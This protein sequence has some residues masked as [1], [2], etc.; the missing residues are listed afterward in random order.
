[1]LTSAVPAP[2]KHQG[3]LQ[4]L[5]APAHPQ[6]LYPAPAKHQAIS[7]TLPASAHPH[8]RH[9][10]PQ[11]NQGTPPTQPLL[12]LKLQSVSSATPGPPSCPLQ[13]LLTLY[14]LYLPAWLHQGSLPSQPP[15]HPR[16]WPAP[17]K[18]QGPPLLLPGALPL[19][20][21]G[22]AL[23]GTRASCPPPSSLPAF[24][25]C[26]CSPRAPGTPPVLQALLPSPQAVPALPKHLAPSPVPSLCHP[27]RL[28]FC[29]LKELGPLSLPA[30]LSSVLCLFPKHQGITPPV[31]QSPV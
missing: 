24:T 1:M 18:H 19:S 16:P 5:P 12:I 29:S 15:V 30:Q 9:L 23:W 21:S 26:T 10:L 6:R 8:S 31:L 3:H 14:R 27:H 28:Y 7:P 11:S 17:P 20:G 4:V 22:T 25:G 2:P 13:A